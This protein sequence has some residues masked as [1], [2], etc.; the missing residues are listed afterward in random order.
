MPTSDEIQFDSKAAERGYDRTA[1]LRA[2][3]TDATLPRAD[4]QQVAVFCLRQA[5]LLERPDVK[6]RFALLPDALLPEGARTTFGDLA[7]ALWHATVQRAAAESREAGARV[8]IALVQRAGEV[9]SRMMRVAE[10]VL[11]DDPDFGREVASIRSGSGY[12]DSAED[13]TRL[14]ILYEAHRE[15][16]SAGGVH[17]RAGDAK[18][19]KELA[20]QI[21]KELGS[22]ETPAAAKARDESARAFRALER[23]YQSIRRWGVALFDDGEILFP[24]LYSV[25]RS[26]GGGGGG[27][28]GP[29][30]DPGGDAPLPTP[31]TG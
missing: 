1:A 17:Y 16:V 14:A 28:G 6:A 5:R 20:A 4:L 3:I 12:A 25:G 24:S 26:S 23:S 31:V 29:S 11:G 18:L 13:L 22:S 8:P 19:A 9:R 15:R 2:A 30:G 27:S 7:W 21:L 10:Y